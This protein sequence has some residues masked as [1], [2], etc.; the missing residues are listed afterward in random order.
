M[1]LFVS[2]VSAD[3]NLRKLGIVLVHPT[4]NYDLGS[5]FSGDD[6]KRAA[7]LTAAITGGT[8]TWKRT[9]GGSTE[10]AT[11]YDPDFLD[12]ENEETGG[13]REYRGPTFEDIELAGNEPDDSAVPGFTG[14][15]LTTLTFYRS[16]SQVTAN[17]KALITITY[18]SGATA[19]L[20][21]T[22]VWQYFE[23]NG[24]TVRRTATL[25]NTYVSGVLTNTQQ[26]IT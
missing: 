13:R 17:R 16:S 3:V 24:T 14:G 12:T 5:Q 11:D 7:D 15:L 22:E 26:V 23:A 8:L 6:L 2:T 25:T 20:P 10:V 18:G 4:T 9:S 19:G 21:V 1:G